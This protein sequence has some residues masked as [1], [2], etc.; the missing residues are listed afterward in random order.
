MKGPSLPLKFLCLKQFFATSHSVPV[1]TQLIWYSNS[2]DALTINTLPKT[3]YLTAHIFLSLTVPCYIA[4]SLV[5]LIWILHL[6]FLSLSVFVIVSNTGLDLYLHSNCEGFHCLQSGSGACLCKI[7]AFF[8]AWWAERC[9]GGKWWGWGVA[10][11]GQEGGKWAGGKGASKERPPAL[12][13]RFPSVCKRDATY[14]KTLTDVC[15][16]VLVNSIICA[17]KQ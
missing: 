6:H 12:C 1:L 16:R 11:R 14:T 10:G 3:K 9:E 13:L 15:T 8:S 7:E 2:G 4:A 17:W 5:I